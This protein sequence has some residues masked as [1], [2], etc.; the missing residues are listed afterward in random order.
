MHQVCAGTFSKL[1]SVGQ[2]RAGFRI[3]PV[4]QCKQTLPL[5]ADPRRAAIDMQITPMGLMGLLTIHSNAGEI[6][7]L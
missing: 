6:P 4:C 7:H 1:E 2:T 5:M 3:G